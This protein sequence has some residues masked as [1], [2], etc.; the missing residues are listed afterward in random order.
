MNMEAPITT[1]PTTTAPVTEPP[2]VRET[3]TTSN[4]TGGSLIVVNNANLYLPI[5]LDELIDKELKENELRDNEY[6]HRSENN[7]YLRKVAVDNLTEA[8]KAYKE[9]MGE[10]ERFYIPEIKYAFR[11]VEKQQSIYDEATD[12]TTIALPGGSDYH[13]GLSFRFMLLD[14]ENKAYYPLKDVPKVEKWMYDNLPLFGFVDRYPKYGN[15]DFKDTSIVGY[16]IFRYVGLPHSVYISQNGISLEDYIDKLKSEYCVDEKPEFEK[17]DLLEIELDGT[18]YYVLYVSAKNN[19]A[20][21]SI[22]E[23]TE[24]YSSSGDNIGG[25]V[26][27]LTDKAQEQIVEN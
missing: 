8:F 25:F 19:G 17:S 14:E 3:K 13:T 27:V 9:A 4:I 5:E 7:M 20:V 24:V 10:D 6:Y 23:N 1:A 21:I 15:T 2:I 26:F 11:T 18:K 16:G 12:K 22:P